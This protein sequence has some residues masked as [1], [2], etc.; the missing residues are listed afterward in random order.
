MLFALGL[1]AFIAVVASVTVVMLMAARQATEDATPPSEPTDFVAPVSSGGYVWRGTDESPD[2]F[3][4][5][6][7]REN[8]K[9]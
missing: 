6:I 3:R 8:A 7:A 2:E 1:G 9:R 5:R 4:A